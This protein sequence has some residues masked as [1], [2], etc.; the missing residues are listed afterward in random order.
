MRSAINLGIERL[1]PKMN[2]RGIV[3]SLCGAGRYSNP[4]RKLIK[5]T[6]IAF[7]RPTFSQKTPG[8]L[9]G[10]VLRWRWKELTR[11]Y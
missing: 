2:T 11:N 7:A 9:I 4:L 8:D 10:A 5:R 6:I 1:G 3:F